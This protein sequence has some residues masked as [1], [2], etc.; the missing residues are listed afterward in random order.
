MPERRKIICH[1]CNVDM[2]QVIGDEVF[3]IDNV[4]FCVPEVEKYRCLRCCEVVYTSQ[5]VKRIERC[6]A[7]RREFPSAV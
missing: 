7:A 3:T 4:R 2:V 1:N 5:E 6:I